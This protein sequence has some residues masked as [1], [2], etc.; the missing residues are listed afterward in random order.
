MWE[1]SWPHLGNNVPSEANIFGD[2][3]GH[4]NG[5]KVPKSLNLV[6]DC[7]SVWH[8]GSVI[9]GR[10]TVWANHLVNLLVDSFC[11]DEWDQGISFLNFIYFYLNSINS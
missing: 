2:H 9:K 6:D 4:A 7:I 1:P 10:K 11:I 8:F 3:M 5:E